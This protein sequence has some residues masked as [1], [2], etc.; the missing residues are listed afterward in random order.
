M[1]DTSLCDSNEIM[2]K[3]FN[4]N[5]RVQSTRSSNYLLFHLLFSGERYSN[6][7]FNT[8]NTIAIFFIQIQSGE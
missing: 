7:K 6:E 5:K 4:R 2:T 1:Y 3:T 8:F